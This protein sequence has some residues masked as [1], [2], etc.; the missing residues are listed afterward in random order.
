MSH[1]S[2]VTRVVGNLATLVGVVLLA[3]WGI[4]HAAGWLGYRPMAFCTLLPSVIACAYGT[5]V[6][7]TCIGVTMW[8]V[9]LGRSTSGM[10]LAIS[11]AL[12]FALPLV[13]PRYLGVVCIS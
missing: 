3:G 9:S 12:I 4:D 5:G 8:A 2:L 6:L 11:G 7:T 13:L 1:A 10:G